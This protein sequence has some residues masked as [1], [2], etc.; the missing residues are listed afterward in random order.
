MLAPASSNSSSTSACLL[1]AH[2]AVLVAE[3]VPAL[4]ID[5]VHFEENAEALA[6]VLAMGKAKP[7]TPE[8]A[9][10]MSKSFDSIPDPES[11][12]KTW[13]LLFSQKALIV[14]LPLLPTASTAFLKR[15]VKIRSSPKS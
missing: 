2:G 9:E 15:L 8:E 12:I 13:R 4:L 6:R 5:A 14:I 11:F 3:N 10:T 7:L 1:R